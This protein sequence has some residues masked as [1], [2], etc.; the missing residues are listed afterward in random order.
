MPR[1]E[2]LYVIDCEKREDKREP[3]DN[4]DR[5]PAH[6]EMA[7][8]RVDSY[9]MFLQDRSNQLIDIIKDKEKKKLWI[10]GGAYAVFSL[11]TG[12]VVNIFTRPVDNVPDLF[13][14]PSIIV[15]SLLVVGVVLIYTSIIK[16][17][18]ALKSDC[19]LATRQL[20]CLRQSINSVIFSYIEKHFPKPL[21]EDMD[22][23]RFAGTIKDT[24]TDYWELYGQHDKYALSNITFRDTYKKGSIYF[25]S[26][27]LYSVLVIALFASMLIITPI[28][29]LAYVH[30]S[31]VSLTPAE[32]FI[33]GGVSFVSLIVFL[34]LVIANVYIEMKR[35]NH[36]LAP[37]QPFD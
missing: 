23:R 20:N 22:S 28:L 11:I 18:L 19:I 8:A 35:M 34:A 16:Y 32:I 10:V 29:F 26:A 2:N 21:P 12:V 36:Y 25:R 30:E 17:I 5:D 9:L 7:R 6:R 15:I 3:D 27:D 14:V 31:Q 1:S 37:G 4:M 33:S 24:E 13:A